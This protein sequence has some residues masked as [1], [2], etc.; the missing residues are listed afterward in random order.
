ML[1][2]AKNN[3]YIEG[4]LAEKTVYRGKTDKG[5]D[6]LT[7]NLVIRIEEGYEVPVSLRANKMTNDGRENSIYKSLETVI[8]EYKTIADVGLEEAEKVKISSGKLVHNIYKGKDGVVRKS[9]SI[10]SNFVNRIKETDEFKPQARFTVEGIVKGIVDVTNDDGD[11][12]EQKMEFLIPVYGGKLN[13]VTLNI[14]SPEAMEYTADNLAKGTYMVF[15]G[16]IKLIKEKTEKVIKRDFGADRVETTFK[17]INKYEMVGASVLDE[18]TWDTKEI[19]EA[20]KE[21]ENYIT[22]VQNREATTKQ[23]NQQVPTQTKGNSFGTQS[24]VGIDEIPF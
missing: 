11:L 24:T 3:V 20:V 9:Q 17:T 12:I 1:K 6:T 15:D 2:E 13:V 4:I 18:E 21:L 5:V 19:G 10:K 8:E 22:E 14:C 23:Q 7:V 16:V